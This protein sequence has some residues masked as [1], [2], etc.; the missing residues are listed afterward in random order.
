MSS[1]AASKFRRNSFIDFSA[2]DKLGTGWEKCSTPMSVEFSFKLKGMLVVFTVGFR[3]WVHFT[4]LKIPLRTT[5]GQ[6]LHKDCEAFVAL[7]V[8]SLHILKV[9]FH[10]PLSWK[11]NSELV[12]SKGGLNSFLPL[13]QKK[14]SFFEDLQRKQSDEK[15]SHWVCSTSRGWYNPHKNQ[16]PPSTDSILWQ[17][18]ALHA[19]WGADLHAGWL[20]CP[21]CDKRRHHWKGFPLLFPGTAVILRRASCLTGVG[22][23][24]QERSAV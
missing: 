8:L 7:F 19:D 4:F 1:G 9:L 16:S 2:L 6:D 24:E 5:R 18:W 22:L 20:H 10:H 23:R 11:N 14:P 21:G 13:A 12:R 17:R 3:H 15:W